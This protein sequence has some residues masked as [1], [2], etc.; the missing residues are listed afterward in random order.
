MEGKKPVYRLHGAARGW[1]TRLSLS[2][3]HTHAVAVALIR[4]ADG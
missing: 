4:R 3:T 2:H 1:E